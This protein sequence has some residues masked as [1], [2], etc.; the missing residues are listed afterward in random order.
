MQK[1]R[2]GIIG[3]GL[4]FEQLHY[5]AYQRLADKFEI[6]AIC[7]TDTAKLEKWKGILGLSGADLYTDY[8]A[9]LDRDDI[10][11]FDIMLPIELNFKVTAE[12]AQA[13]KPII[14]EKPLA[15]TKEQ[16]LKAMK[17]PQ[18]Y[19]VPIMIAEN[20]RY[21]EENNILRDLVRTKEV[22]DVY[23][24]IQ[25]RVVD[26]PEDMKKGGFASTEWRQH[27]EYPGG[28][29]LDTGVH[30]AAALRHI[31]GPVEAVH[32]FGVE[33]DYDFAPYA[34]VQA[35][36]KFKS[37]VIGQFTFFC[38]GK[39]MQRPLVGLR[40]F[41]SEGMIYHEERGCGTINVA[42]NDGGTKQIPYEPNTGLYNELLNF[43]KAAVGEEPLSVP[44]ELE[45][46]DVLTIFAILE[47]A[48][49]NRIV[50]VD[51]EREYEPAY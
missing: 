16:A 32:A 47:S 27:P 43:Y 38:T 33:Q 26:F 42:Y 30:D 2:M 6:A 46:G 23:Y 50:E 15:P 24:F 45:Y 41:G 28:V 34:V 35:N 20:Y 7:D 44:P 36:L 3:T 4:A 39:E 48:R 13:G 14:C 22:G 51:L 18:R 12:V 40:I 19:G 31:F 25:N 5:P 10:D 11:A 1:L 29:I 49:E 17:L 9:M 21:N 37:G 8:R